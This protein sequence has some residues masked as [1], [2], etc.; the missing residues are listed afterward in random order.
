MS[1]MAIRSFRRFLR[2]ALSL[3]PSDLIA[4]LRRRRPH[5][6]VGPQPVPIPPQDRNRSAVEVLQR[7]RPAFP[8]LRRG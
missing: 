8:E 7:R 4:P 5:A 1:R 6:G 2:R 3:R